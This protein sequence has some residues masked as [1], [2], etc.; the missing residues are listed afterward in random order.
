[1]NNKKVRKIMNITMIMVM[2]A[3]LCFIAYG[4][5]NHLFSSQ[6]SLES[7]VV[8]FGIGAPFIFIIFQA[9]QVVFPIIPGGISLLAGVIIFGPVNGFIY[10]YIGIIMGSAI[11]FLLA[12]HYGTP[13][14]ETLFGKKLKMKY[15]KW[16]DN[17]KFPKL[18]AIAIFFPVAPDDF[19]CYLAGTTNMK[20]RNFMATILLGKPLSIAAYS[21]GLNVIMTHLLFMVH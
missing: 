4:M 21:F 11:A 5:K 8:K 3:T 14:L 10:N 9:I 19:L 6:G 7:F 12:K 2:L 1:M 13:I 17:K 18:F 20:F 15:M 16:A